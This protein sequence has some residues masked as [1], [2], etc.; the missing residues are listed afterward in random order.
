VLDITIV[1]D[2]GALTKDRTGEP[3]WQPAVI[4]LTGGDSLEAQI[5]T[6]G[7][8]RRRRCSLPPLKLDVPRGRANRTSLG[9]LNKPKIVTHCGSAPR[10]EQYVVQEY[11][12]YRVYEMLTP[13]SHRA[14]LVRMT[15]VDPKDRSVPEPR[16]AI[17][18][19]E[20]DDVAERTGL[21]VLEATGA[22]PDDLDPYQSALVGVFQYLIGNTD[23]SATALH[24]VVLLQSMT[25]TY[26][27]AYDFD[28]AGAVSTTYAA[29]DRRLGIQTVRERLYRGFCISEDRWNDVFEHVR[30]KKDAIWELYRSEPALDDRIRDR[31]LAYFDEFF[32]IIDDPAARDRHIVQSCRS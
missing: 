27:M 14:R 9:G 30:S 17:V 5:R 18:L 32:R 1:T 6:R 4:R 2:F 31:T 12:L 13:L 19:E 16:Y 23:W 15:Y 20:D 29:P 11:L 25:T 22:R 24:N 3:Q 21:R 28:F 8:F 10:Y 26:P 7:E